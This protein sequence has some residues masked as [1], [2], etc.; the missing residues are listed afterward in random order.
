MN[1]L[2]ELNTFGR[3]L[4]HA[5]QLPVFVIQPGRTIE[6]AYVDTAIADNPF[7]ALL[8]EEIA[9]YAYALYAAEQPIHF[10]R[11]RLQYF[12]V[13]ANDEDRLIGTIVVGPYLHKKQEDDQWLETVE[14]LHASNR[15]WLLELY[16]EISIVTEERAQALSLMVHFAIRRQ[17]VD[18]SAALL[19]TDLLFHTLVEDKRERDAELSLSRRSGMLHTNLSHER[20]LLHYVR[21]GERERVRTFVMESIVGEDEFGLL[22][23]RSRLR[24]EKNLMITGIALICRAAIEGGLHEEDALTLSDSY[25]QQLEEKDKLQEVIRIM[26]EALFDFVDRV[27]DVRRGHYSPAVQDCLHEI[28]NQLYGEI[29]LDRLA[30]LTHL[31]PNY[32]SGLFKKEVGLTI[33]EYVQRERIEEAKRLLALTDYPITDIA[34]WLNFSDQSY[35]NKVFKRWQGSTPKSY[36]QSEQRPGRKRAEPS[37]TE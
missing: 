25:I 3:L 23:K 15:G 16:E 28:A 20:V 32:L 29:T 10:S 34:T 37:S 24:S 30:E 12:F 18:P 26:R 4:H 7:F 5:L 13:N 17:A 21:A 31:S 11:A 8:R 19:S 27:A 1:T 35:F 36:R 22:S 14:E 2:I 9:G 33:S 6:S